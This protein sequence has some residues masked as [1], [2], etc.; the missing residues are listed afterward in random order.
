M[1]VIAGTAKGRTL[2]TLPS[3]DTRPTSDRAKES[4][5]NI[6]MPY[7]HGAGFLDLFS[8]SGAIGI[9]ALSRGASHAVFVE[10]SAQAVSII[11]ENLTLTRLSGSAEVR[12][13]TV[14]DFLLNCNQP[15]PLI[16]MD[17]PYHSELV[18]ESVRIIAQNK[19]LQAEGLLIAE[20]DRTEEFPEFLFGF[21]L[22]DKRKY[23]RN[24]LNFYR[25]I[26]KKQK[27]I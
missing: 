4:L 13:S 1:R 18:P 25:E 19:L 16:F 23:G 2:R 6:L 11:K 15:F 22:V 10:Q 20:G 8:G 3:D 21:S 17:P 26:E 7:L 24:V 27:N 14:M 12:Q 9:E 5:F